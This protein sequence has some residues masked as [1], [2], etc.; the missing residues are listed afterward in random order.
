MFSYI[1]NSSFIGLGIFGPGRVGR[2]SS[3]DWRRPHPISLTVYLR[4]DATAPR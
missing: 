1:E 2:G 3:Q 4:P